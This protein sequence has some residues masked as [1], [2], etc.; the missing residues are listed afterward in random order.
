MIKLY[1]SQNLLK[2]YWVGRN[3]KTETRSLV[4]DLFG[5]SAIILVS[6]NLS[7]KC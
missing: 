3:K 6:L 5:V 7:Q 4:A 1:Y 2:P